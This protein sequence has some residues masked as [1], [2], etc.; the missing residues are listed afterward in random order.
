M[1]PVA[2]QSDRSHAAAPLL[3]L[4]VAAWTTVWACAPPSTLPAPIPMAR[5]DGV[6][7]G[8]GATVSLAAGEDCRVEDR[9]AFDSGLPYTPT[10]STVL[11]PMADGASWGVVPLSDRWAMGWQLGAGRATPGITGGAMGRYD[12]TKS[13]RMLIGAQLELGAFWASV[14]VPASFE[15]R[16]GLWLYTHPSVG[17]RLSGL[18]RIPVGV[19]VPLGTR[20][21][22]DMEGGVAYPFAEGLNSRYA[23]VRSPRGWFGVGLSTTVGR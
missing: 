23:S 19:G 21:R 16:D 20:L 1:L 18:G 7:L 22:L 13:D 9:A 6:L 15:L 3:W 17:L 8:G 14:G 10:C 11:Q 12:F 2:P 5:G 4:L